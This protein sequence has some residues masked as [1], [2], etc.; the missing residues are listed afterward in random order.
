MMEVLRTWYPGSP[1]S[2]SISM[3]P[4]ASSLSCSSVLVPEPTAWAGRDWEISLEAH[5][6]DRGCRGG[7][8]VGVLGRQ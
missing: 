1:C 6:S 5:S 8:Q 2:K 3:Q 4:W 7:R